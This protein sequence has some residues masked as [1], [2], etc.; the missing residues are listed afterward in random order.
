MMLSLLRY[1]KYIDEHELSSDNHMDSE[2]TDLHLL[3]Y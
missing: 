2:Q 3:H 1:E